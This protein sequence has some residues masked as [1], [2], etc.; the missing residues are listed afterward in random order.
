MIFFQRDVEFSTLP[1]GRCCFLISGVK[2]RGKRDDELGTRSKVNRKARR[3]TSLLLPP[4]SFPVNEEFFSVGFN[5]AERAR[6][7]RA[8]A[9][10][11]RVRTELRPRGRTASSVIGASNLAFFAA[12]WDPFILRGRKYDVRPPSVFSERREIR[13]RLRCQRRLRFARGLLETDST[14]TPRSVE[15]S[16]RN[17]KYRDSAVRVR[18]ASQT[19]DGYYALYLVKMRDTRTIVNDRWDVRATFWGLLGYFRDV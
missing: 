9:K 11:S 18:N 12:P 16:A 6:S 8:S 1:R 13:V 15:Y 19:V 3:R 14:R 10:K 4:S 2:L 17:S 5:R 7:P